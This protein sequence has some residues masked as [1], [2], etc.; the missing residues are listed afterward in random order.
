MVLKESKCTFGT[1]SVAYLGHVISAARVEMDK[2]KVAAVADW[3]V[4]HSVRAVRS[5]LGFVGY[6]RRFIKDYG[7]ITSLLISLLKREHFRWTVETESAFQALE[8]A[9]AIAPVLWPPPPSWSSVM[10][11]A[12]DSVSSYIKV[13][14][15]W[16]SS[17]VPS[18]PDMSN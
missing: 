1:L 5:S 18:P 6:N 10:L 3:L 2:Q 13:A 15:R 12:W 7:V 14:G 4:P 16:C 8:K 11:P 9:L 17:V